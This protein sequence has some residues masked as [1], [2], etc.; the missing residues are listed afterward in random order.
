MKTNAFTKKLKSNTGASILLALAFFLMCFF[1]ASVV[2][3]SA[4]VN[5]SRAMAQKEEQRSFFAIQSAQNLIK[6]MFGEINGANRSESRQTVKL[7]PA[8][9]VDPLTGTETFV[10]DGTEQ[11]YD[12]TYVFGGFHLREEKVSYDWCDGGTEVTYYGKWTK[13]ADGPRCVTEV[14]SS[15]I[16]DV[17]Y[18]TETFGVNCVG[19]DDA[20]FLK[21]QL[22]EIG[23]FVLCKQLYEDGVRSLSVDVNSN[24]AK[25]FAKI[26]DEDNP[27]S[28]DSLVYYFDIIPDEGSGVHEKN[29]PTVHVK[30]TTDDKA[31][32]MFELTVDSRTSVTYSATVKVRS[33]FEKVTPSTVPADRIRV[34]CTHGENVEG[35]YHCERTTI[36]DTFLS[37]YTSK[38]EVSKGVK[39]TGTTTTTSAVGG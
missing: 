6:D 24:F 26:S 31:N 7:N 12:T 15:V 14:G 4:S 10:Y 2:M 11:V 39:D 34:P 8:K 25:A 21:S 29:I 20:V 36:T 1:V 27:F 33:T 9:T 30:M 19:N 22:D 18:S 16:K 3:A 32:L 38:I 35:K 17:D 37:W 5:A 13:Q 23:T 28:F